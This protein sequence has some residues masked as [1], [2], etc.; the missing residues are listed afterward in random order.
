ME[1]HCLCYIVV[2]ACLHVTYAQESGKTA[3]VYT[4]NPIIDI[5]CF[6]LLSTMVTNC[7]ISLS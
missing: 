2:A 3:R 6:P 4:D 7:R 1:F 5:K